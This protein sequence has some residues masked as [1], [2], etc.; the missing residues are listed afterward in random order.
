MIT[1]MEK[2]YLDKQGKRKNQEC[3]GR[4]LTGRQESLKHS[5]VTRECRKDVSKGAE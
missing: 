2:G 3:E 1:L 4:I 5:L